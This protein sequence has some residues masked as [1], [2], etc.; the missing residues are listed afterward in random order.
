[1]ELGTRESG[2]NVHAINMSKTNSR[3]MNVTKQ[4]SWILLAAFFSG[5]AGLTYEIL[6]NRSL[7][8]VYGS[9][10]YSTAGILAAFMA[11]LAIGAALIAHWGGRIRA[12]LRLFAAVEVGVIFFAII[13]NRYVELIN[14][15]MV[16]W[17]GILNSG[18]RMVS[19]F[20]GASSVL[21]PT[22]AM[23]AALPLLAF[24][25]QTVNKGRSATPGILYGMNTLGAVIGAIGAGFLFIPKLGMQGT[26]VVAILFGLTAIGIALL[27]EVSPRRKFAGYHPRE[28]PTNPRQG[29]FIVSLLISGAC[30]LGYEVVWTR[31]LI[32]I[33]GSTTYA[34]SLTVGIFVLGT[35]L[36]SLYMGRRVG[37]LRSPMEVFLHI[38]VAVGLVASVTL[39]LYGHLPE[40]YMRLIGPLQ[41][42]GGIFLLQAILTGA[43]MLAP[44]FLIG[45]SFPV[46]VRVMKGTESEDDGRPFSAIFGWISA[47]NVIGVLVTSLLLIPA[48]GLQSTVVA[49]AI[50]NMGV[51]LLVVVA[52]RE[53]RYRTKTVF[54][55]T[56]G[57][58]ALSVIQPRWDPIVM[59]S[60]VYAKVPVFRQLAKSDSDLKRILAMYRLEYYKEGIE[61]VVSVVRMPSV[62]RKPY[63]AL[64]VDGKVDASTGKDMSTQV[65]SGHL[66]FVFHPEADEILI[67]GL[68]SGVTVGSVTT[69]Q[70][71]NITCVE[72]EPAMADAA[73]VFESFNNHALDD[74]RVNLVFDDGRHYL[75]VSNRK[76]DVIISEPSNPWMSGPSRLFTL[77]FFKL[78]SSRLNS[79]GIFAQWMP[80]YGLS[81]ELLAALARSFT[82]VFPHTLAF[83]VSEGDMLV[84]GSQNPLVLSDGALV[85]MFNESLQTSDLKRVGI[86][87]PSKLLSLLIGGNKTMKELGKDARLNTDENGLLEFGSPLYLQESTLPENL[88][89]LENIIAVSAS[90]VGNGSINDFGLASYGVLSSNTND[91]PIKIQ[92]AELEIKRDN[93]ATAD[94]ILGLLESDRNLPNY[95]FLKGI[96]ALKMGHTEE[97]ETHFRNVEDY[98][99]GDLRVL[100]PVFRWLT[101]T[102]VGDISSAEINAAEFIRKLRSLRRAAERNEQL[103]TIDMIVETLEPGN[104]E[105]LQQEEREKLQSWLKTELFSPLESYYRGVSLLFKGRSEAASIVLSQAGDL[106]NESD[107]GSM[108]FYFLAVALRENI[109]ETARKLLIRFTE[110]R[111]I[112]NSEDDWLAGDVNLLMTELNELIE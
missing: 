25:L 22:V 10:T 100:L 20:M 26:L 79:D 88:A 71:R 110:S 103:D 108:I 41:D 94:S 8:L 64:A 29:A 12:P 7:L 106:L 51:G 76:F 62:S 72:I 67:I 96:A 65:L 5:A 56:I 18:S 53:I 28:L 48:L 74:P 46:A 13:F 47:G 45:A 30:A 2:Y 58:I 21:L 81:Q 95:H 92:L 91:E 86:N 87:S 23:G 107:P 16:S 11:G 44:T 105:W 66:P 89:F 36:G 17:D 38:N 98:L 27:I 112:N 78:A 102:R 50:G 9:T 57:M 39:Y 40:F 60:G 34:F 104:L 42:S 43:V 31:I 101:A 37:K 61:S 52:Y 69:H 111:N 80:L 32:L 84:L 82:E 97:A 99:H 77:E 109:P 1:M 68:A 3:T 73:R 14:G 85:R 59:T 15:W 6:W 93:P 70:V 55:V 49:L 90:E 33:I 24:A 54:A 4:R 19:L 63:L 83:R 75:T 35:S